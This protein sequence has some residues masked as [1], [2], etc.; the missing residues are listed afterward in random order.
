MSSRTP[1]ETRT[2]REAWPTPEEETVVTGSDTLVGGPPPVPPPEAAPPADRRIGAGMLLGLGALALVAAGLLIAWLLTHQK[3]DH[4]TTTVVVTSAPRTAALPPKVA[5]PRLVGL[6]EEQAVFRLG[7]IGLRPKEVFRPTKQPKGVV[8]SQKPQ[9]A[10]EAVRGSPVTLVIDSGAPKVAV[11][12]LTGSSFTDAQAKLDQLGLGSTKTEVTSTEP[13]G[14][15]V[16]QAP[17]AGG[18]L[19]KGSTVTLS[20]AKAQSQ[21]TTPTTNATTSAATS[22]TTTSASAPPQPQT[23]TM[24]SVTGQKEAAA[25]TALGN[26]G[27]FD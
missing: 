23:A 2:P 9:E 26:A 24:A 10:T 25:V 1:P 8:V 16:D 19:A 18:K 7:Q 11:P 6:K 21:T 22:P 3:N 27:R 14:T 20:V 13:P 17:K 12:D 5:V 4:K 15:V